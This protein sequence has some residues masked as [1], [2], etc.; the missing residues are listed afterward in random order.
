[1]HKTF[2]LLLL[3]HNSISREDRLNGLSEICS[4]KQHA[5]LGLVD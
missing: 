5:G 3:K 2:V 1:M 4:G